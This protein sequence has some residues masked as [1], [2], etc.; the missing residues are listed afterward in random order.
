MKYITHGYHSAKHYWML[1]L[2]LA[3]FYQKNLQDD[4]TVYLFH[5]AACLTPDTNIRRANFP[6]IKELFSAGYAFKDRRLDS[7]YLLQHLH[8]EKLLE[9]PTCIFDFSSVLYE[10]INFPIE[11][12]FIF[13]YGYG[14]NL[15]NYPHV[16]DMHF[17][18]VNVFP[19]VGNVFILNKPISDELLEYSI[20]LF[21]NTKQV[22]EE[23]GL[24]CPLQLDKFCLGQILLMSELSLSVKQ[25]LVSDLGMD[26]GNFIN[27]SY[28]LYPAFIPDQFNYS[29]GM[30]RSL[31]YPHPYDA[32]LDL[33]PTL[34][35]NFMRNL[36]KSLRGEN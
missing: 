24:P 25:D 8:K 27:Y 32:I 13:S 29:D 36:V 30:S 3:S 17:S 28:G 15:K 23:K 9:Y 14:D 11:K 20:D 2:L 18:K 35:C 19:H 12:D 22:C 5:D 6:N 4:L 16:W 26:V 7:L 34:P 10:P 33:P 1:E 21:L 31:F